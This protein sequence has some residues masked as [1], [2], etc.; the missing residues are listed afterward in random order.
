MTKLERLLKQDGL[1]IGAHRGF[2]AV[3][4]ENTLLAISEGVRLGVDVVEFDLYITKDGVPV[5]CHDYDL[6]R[7]SNGTG[8]VSQ[9]TLAE[10]KQ[11]D[12]GIH[13]GQQFEGLALS[14]VEQ[15]LEYMKAYPDVLM[16]VDF[17]VCPETLMTVKKVIPMLEAGGFM[18][19]C[20]FNCI[21]CDIVDYITERYG[22][23]VI[24]APH[25]FPWRVNFKPGKDGSLSRMWGICIPEN[26]LDDDHVHMYRDL[27]IAL[28]TTPA[29]T[30]EAVKKAMA[31]N[32][33]LPLCNDPRAY[34]A[35]NNR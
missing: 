18:D 23:C 27:G 17:K 31:Y 4:P 20:V 28:V 16:D 13:R 10:L 1:F 5:V 7:C 12:F 22:K 3:Y 2:S 19:R 29:D 11:L 25:D 15:V 33:T 34:L 6:K 24:S 26:M 30:P 35:A 32:V 14:T 8:T 9:H 21:D